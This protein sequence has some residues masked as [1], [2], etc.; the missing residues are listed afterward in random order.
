MSLVVIGRGRIGEALRVAW[1]L[2]PE[3]IRSGREVFAAGPASLG[4]ARTV[5]HVAGPAGENA[6]RTEPLGAMQIH[7]ELT[8]RLATWVRG[9]ITR[10]LIVIHTLAP[11]RTYYG[12]LKRAAVRM[13]QRLLWH[14]DPGETDQLSVI[15]AGQVIGEGISVSAN[16]GVIARYIAQAVTNGTLECPTRSEVCIRVTPMVSL[17]ETLDR[18][19]HGPCLPVVA[20]VSGPISVRELAFLITRLA[21]LAYGVA[22]KIRETESFGQSYVEPTGEPM[23]VRPTAETIMGWLRTVEVKMLYARHQR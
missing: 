10:R 8:E 14:D 17:R 2:K 23:P 16:A 5:I 20:P 6:C 3:Q 22:P 11:E 12:A 15:E 7:Y 9:S 13:A 21:N 1:H 18:L 19:V 4:D